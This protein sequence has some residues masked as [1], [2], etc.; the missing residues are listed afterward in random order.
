MK[1]KTADRFYLDPFL[2][3]TGGD[4]MAVLGGIEVKLG[5]VDH[6]GF[7]EFEEVDFL[8]EIHEVDFVSQEMLDEAAIW[9]ESH[10]DAVLAQTSKARSEPVEQVTAE[11][12]SYEVRVR[13]A[14]PND[15]G[16]WE[17]DIINT[18]TGADGG[19]KYVDAPTIYE[20]LA[21]AV[22]LIPS[23]TW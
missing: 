21:K 22:E 18:D 1:M 20:A 23:V 12:P 16:Q 5:E 15:P 11:L 14:R 3:A 8:N 7:L 17:V 6:S 13:E 19:Y 4:L 9:Y 10:L 2:H